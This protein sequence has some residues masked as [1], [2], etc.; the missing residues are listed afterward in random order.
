M[1]QFLPVFVIEQ[2]PVNTQIV[3]MGDL[4][5]GMGQQAE[6]EGAAGLGKALVE[7][8]EVPV[9]A[10]DAKAELVL[11]E[12]RLQRA[13]KAARQ[14]DHRVFAHLRDRQAQRHHDPAVFRQRVALLLPGVAA[15]AAHRLRQLAVVRLQQ[16]GAQ[17][18]VLAQAQHGAALE[19]RIPVLGGGDQFLEK[20]FLIGEGMV[21][22]LPAQ[23]LIGDR[24]DDLA[25]IH[26]GIQ[27]DHRE[28][29]LLRHRQ[30][31]AR[32]ALLRRP[33]LHA[34]R[35][36]VPLVAFQHIVD[37]AFPEQVQEKGAG[38]NQLSLHHRIVEIRTFQDRHAVEGRVDPLAA[39]QN[40]RVAKRRKLQ[41][42]RNRKRH[43]FFPLMIKPLVFFHP[44]PSAAHVSI[45]GRPPFDFQIFTLFLYGILLY[46]DGMAGMV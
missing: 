1:E 13:Q 15:E 25:K 10:A 46:H 21:V 31:V 28:L 23:D 37:A 8:G 16:Q 42:F 29:Q 33:L 12:R 24:V 7:I 19:K 14:L 39:R 4:L 41:H 36:R 34:Q 26:V 44:R 18:L 38:Q 20:V 43:F 45:C 11:R 40:G 3:E 27:H 9:A 30:D 22:A 17:P 32:Q 5:L 2:D 35:H 6:A